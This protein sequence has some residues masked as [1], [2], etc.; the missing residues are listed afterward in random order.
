MSLSYKPIYY[1][2]GIEQCIIADKDQCDKLIISSCHRIQLFSAE[3]GQN[4]VLVFILL[5]FKDLAS[6]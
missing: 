2:I 6:T 3:K 5:C 4:H 1:V